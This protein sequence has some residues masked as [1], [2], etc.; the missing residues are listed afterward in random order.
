MA[1]AERAYIFGAGGHA[2]VIASFLS[3]EPV[4]VVRDAT[5]PGQLAE[6]AFYRDVAIEEA[7][8]YI[9]I[10]DNAVRTRIYTELAARGIV[11]AICVAPNAFVARDA[12]LAPGAVICSGAIIGSSARIGRNTIVNTLSSLD[13]DCVLGDHSQ[14]AVGVSICGGVTI[15]K[16][17]FFGVKSAVFPNVAIGDNAV[18]RAGSLVVKDVPGDVTV[19]GQPA[20]I[21]RAT[22]SRSSPA[23]ADENSANV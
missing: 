20:R 12:W 14:V 17:C 8:V 16:N 9:G 21:V 7:H 19:G 6:A 22:R 13:H 3:A 11:P 10:G 2:R 18:I 23:R 15:G 5:E 4:F 1:V